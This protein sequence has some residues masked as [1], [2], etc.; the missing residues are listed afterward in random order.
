M[1]GICS[2]GLVQI[3]CRAVRRATLGPGKLERTSAAQFPEKGK[4]AALEKAVPKATTD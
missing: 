4:K 2:F 3:V 1:I